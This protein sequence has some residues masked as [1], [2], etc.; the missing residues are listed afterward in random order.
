[1]HGA[2]ALPEAWTAPLEDRVRSA[3]FGFD[4]MR[5]FELA[6]RTLRVTQS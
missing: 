4:G 1:M 6:E 5:V 2:G 3:L